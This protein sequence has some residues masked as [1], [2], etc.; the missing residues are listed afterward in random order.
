MYAELKHGGLLINKKKVQRLVKKL[1]LQATTYSIKTRKYIYYKCK[2]GRINH[3]RIKR[4]FSTNILRQKI[5]TDTTEFKYYIINGNGVKVTGKLYLDWFID[6]CN[7]EVI[8]YYIS[9][10]PTLQNVISALEKLSKI[11][12]IVVT[13]EISFRS[14]LILSD[15]NLSKN[16]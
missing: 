6:L 8:S 15:E 4:C 10:Q 16:T 12:Q 5:V 2:V 9:K 13:E 3:N 11:L 1:S 7:G 14:R